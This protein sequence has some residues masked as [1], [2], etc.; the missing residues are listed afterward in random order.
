MA[1]KWFHCKKFYALHLCGKGTP[2]VVI[3]HVKFVLKRRAHRRPLC[4]QG[5]VG[6]TPTVVP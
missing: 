3:A 6:Y 1:R 4:R 5:G 2:R